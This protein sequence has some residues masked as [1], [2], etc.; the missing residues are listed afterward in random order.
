MLGSK[1]AQLYSL[2][3]KSKIGD[4]TGGFLPRNVKA[5]HRPHKFGIGKTGHDHNKFPY[6]GNLEPL[7]SKY[8]S[9]FA[10]LK[11]Q[12]TLV[13]EVYFFFLFKQDLNR[14]AATTLRKAAREVKR[15]PLRGSILLEER[16]TGYEQSDYSPVS[17]LIMIQQRDS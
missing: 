14:E 4:K 2:V 7:A 16:G 13:P 9:N 8:K 10:N 1:N 6:I 17:F 3:E 5:F 11:E 15:S 12:S